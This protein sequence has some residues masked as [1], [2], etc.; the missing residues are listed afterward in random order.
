LLA[1]DG[2]VKG[3][4][5]DKERKNIQSDRVVVVPGDKREVSLVRRIY[6]WYVIQGLGCKRIADRLN[7]FGLCND[8]GRPWNPQQ[9]KSL[10][11]NEKYVG[12]NV[13]GRTSRKL[14]GNWHRNLPAD[15]SRANG[16]FPALVDQAKFRAAE[17]IR[18]NRT[19]NLS[20]D[21]ILRRLRDFVRSS[22]VVSAKAIDD[23]SGMPGGK[24][25]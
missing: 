25:Y 15:W 8:H 3:R 17:A 6:D 4:L 10:L 2:T 24:T 1:S 11:S 21:E 13:Y 14:G 7:A 20:D 12:T 16:A 9:I 19:H 23:A 22:E 5:C 18:I